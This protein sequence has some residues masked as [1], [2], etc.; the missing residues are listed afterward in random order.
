MACI[1]CARNLACP[2]DEQEHDRGCTDE[3]GH[4]RPGCVPQVPTV[5]TQP[6][7]VG[8]DRSREQKAAHMHRIGPERNR[9]TAQQPDMQTYCRAPAQQ[10]RQD[11]HVPS[12]AGRSKQTKRQK[13]QAQPSRPSG[14]RPVPAFA[15]PVRQ[16]H[17]TED[18]EQRDI[19]LQ[20]GHK[21]RHRQI[22]LLGDGHRAPHLKHNREAGERKACNEPYLAQGPLYACIAFRPHRTA[23]LQRVAHG[24]RGEHY[25]QRHQH[26]LQK[27]VVGKGYRRNDRPCRSQCQQRSKRL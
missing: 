12:T 6:Y 25:R 21:H 2:V 19:G 14:D 7:P 10:I 20:I 4:T 27:A 8:D 22:A 16:R 11:E 15:E 17:R 23:M 1:A 26:T 24:P 3:I 9:L 13:G 18:R 5:D